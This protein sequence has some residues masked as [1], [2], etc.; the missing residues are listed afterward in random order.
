MKD[1]NYGRKKEL[2]VGEFLERQG[3][4]WGRSP[5]SRGPF[6]IVAQK[7]RQVW[8]IQVKATRG[9]LKSAIARAEAEI[10]S[11]R[12]VASSLSRELQC[13]VKPVIAIVQGN[14]AWLIDVEEEPRLLE[15]GWLEELHY[16]YDE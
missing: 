3:F 7:G 6:D 12:R 16:G 15:E 14:Y 2:Q 11:L 4:R 9:D 10:G 13:P 8:G 5:G 1:P